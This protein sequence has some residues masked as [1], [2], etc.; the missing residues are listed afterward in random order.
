VCA[1]FHKNPE[2]KKTVNHKNG[3]KSDN[4]SVNLEWSTH[5]EQ[6]LHSFRVLGRVQVKNM[7]GRLGALNHRSKPII[8]LSLDGI[9]LFRFDGIAEANRKTGINSSSIVR[10]AKLQQKS[11]GGFIWRYA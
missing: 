11:A 8:Q 7:L 10:S 4:R 9:S 2:K 5:R 3:I 1:S 6:N